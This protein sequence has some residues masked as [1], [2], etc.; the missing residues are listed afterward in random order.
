MTLMIWEWCA[1][2]IRHS[3][4]TPLLVFAA[5]G[6]RGMRRRAQP[7]FGPKKQ[8]AIR[9]EIARTFATPAQTK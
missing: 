6:L 7:A 4:Q 9:L 3:S 1:P 5:V 8:S 2:I